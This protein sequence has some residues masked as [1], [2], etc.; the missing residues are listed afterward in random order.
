MMYRLTWLVLGLLP[1]FALATQPHGQAGSNVAA[2][3]LEAVHDWR[4]SLPTSQGTTNTTSI[5]IRK[6]LVALNPATE[7]DVEFLKGQLVARQQDRQATLE[8]AD[9]Y[10]IAIDHGQVRIRDKVLQSLIQSELERS[11]A[12]L[13]I[14]QVT[15]SPEGVVVEGSIRRLGLWLP[16]YMQ[17]MPTV[18]GAGEVTLT[19]SSLRVAGIPLYKALLATNIQLESLIDMKTN[20][21]ALEGQAM[22]LRLK[23]LLNAPA[24]DFELNTLTLLNGEVMLDLGQAARSPAFFCGAHCPHAF[25]YA[26]GGKVAAAGMVMSGQSVLLTGNRQASLP[27]ALHNLHA[28]IAESTIHMRTDGALWISAQEGPLPAD[29][30]QRLQLGQDVLASLL[31]LVKNTSS[32]DGVLLAVRQATLQTAEGVPLKVGTLVS[33]TQATDLGQIPTALQTV[34]AGEIHLPE[35]ALD[36]LLNKVLF[37]FE[38]S[39]IRKVK[40][41]IETEVIQ[42]NLQVR[43]SLAGIPLIWLPAN[44]EG[45]LAISGDQLGMEFTPAQIDIF[46]LPV[47]KALDFFGLELDQLISIKQPN[48]QLLG[49]VIRIPVNKAMPPL[50]LDTRLLAMQIENNT[51]SNPFITLQVGQTHNMANELLMQSKNLPDGLWMNSPTF[52]ALGLRTGPTIGHL[53]SAE[54]TEH[55]KINLAHYPDL[56]ATAT[57]R[58]PQAGLVW[59]SLPVLQNPIQGKRHKQQTQ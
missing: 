5:E 25:A 12:P 34:H 26:Q 54:T 59:V 23:S 11:K 16:F 4:D 31:P 20:A 49:N 46:G 9:T 7:I 6:S 48:V 45:K 39:P 42:L 2:A 47:N 8:Q 22:L 24:I 57:L 14:T 10:R 56:L 3:A 32:P 36:A 29:E 19:P 51:R 41:S 17:G 21:V 37:G 50:Q 1:A 44:L 33:S 35:H 38:G 43:P 18:L 58:M 55:L 52:T 28:L 15:L 13:R 53:R 30:A 40:S 27:I